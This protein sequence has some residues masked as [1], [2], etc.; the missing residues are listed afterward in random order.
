VVS[1]VD[2]EVSFGEDERG[3]R[4][5]IVT[6]ETGEKTEYLVPHGKHLRVHQ[7]DHVMAGERLCEGPI[8]PHD[9][10][11]INGEGAVQK[12]LVNEI[13]EVYRLQG[14]NINDKHIECIVRQM[15]R[16]I[17]ISDEGDSDHIE[18]QSISKTDVV[19]T[20]RIIQESGG[21][22]AQYKPQLLGITKASL[23]TDSFISA[24]SFQ[25][26]TRVLSDAAVAG[27]VD[28]LTG[29]KENVIMGNLIPCGTGASPYQ[30]IHIKDLDAE[31]RLDFDTEGEDIL[32]VAKK[33]EEPEEILF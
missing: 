16:R 24:A 25:E 14:V 28:R 1:E 22:P 29:L 19:I 17:R 10:L 18:G 11:R 26:T 7:G 9:I 2:G 13:Q 4:K 8:D 32:D 33:G 20:N 23:A 12:Y 6:D 30:N 15:L 21:T 3:Y 27:R 5:I 31:M